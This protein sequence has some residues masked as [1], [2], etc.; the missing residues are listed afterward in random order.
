M[1]RIAVW[2]TAFLGD[3]VLTLPVIQS[4]KRHFPEAAIDFYVRGG[5]GPL[6]AAHPDISEVFDYAKR[7]GQ[8]GLAGLRRMG[9][10]VRGRRYDAWINAH[11]SLRSALICRMSG[12][13][14]RVGYL[15]GSLS[16]LACTHRVPRRFGRRDE[17]ERLLGLLE[18]LGVPLVD[19]WP[20]I[21][22]AEEVRR[23][24]EAFF[25]DLPGPV[26][27]MHPGSVW[28]T[29]RW[30]AEYF[31]DVG[32][33]ALRHGARVVLFA[34]PG[35]EA[36][37]GEVRERMTAATGG[38]GLTDM[39]GKLD[40]PRLAAW[41]ARLSCYLTNDSGPMHL[42]WAQRVPTVAL[43]GPTVRELGFFPRGER[44]KVFETP[45][46]CRPCGLH[47]PQQCP[48]GTHDCMRLIEPERVWAGVARELA[49]A[50]TE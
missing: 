9:G 49:P 1:E 24:A 34:G 16:S 28:A 46:S 7:G 17:L 37:A 3:A 31:A 12:A 50:G 26:L 38:A 5:L 43:F 19:T 14:I 21:A 13:P 8:A 42:A 4:L 6:F 23:E 30:P 39:S 20:R 33:R 18:P 22:V 44:S 48:K 27:G 32:A 10:T 45:L 41:I 36:V 40:L 35:E 2:N 15:E 47:G 25:A 11:L 29:K